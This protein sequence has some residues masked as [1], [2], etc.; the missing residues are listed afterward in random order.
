MGS[1][2]LLS[3]WTD[4]AREFPWA[5]AAGERLLTEGLGDLEPGVHQNRH[6]LTVEDDLRGD[7]GGV[8][9]FDADAERGLLSLLRVLDGAQ[10]VAASVVAED[11]L[12]DFGLFKECG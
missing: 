2:L 7:R 3:L 11:L 8:L 1:S 6:G 9:G 12:L 10:T 5:R 4:E